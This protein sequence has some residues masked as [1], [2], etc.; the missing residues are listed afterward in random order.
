MKNKIN[1]AV[2]EIQTTFSDCNNSL[3]HALQYNNKYWT[4]HS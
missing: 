3:T 4:F 2:L 1:K